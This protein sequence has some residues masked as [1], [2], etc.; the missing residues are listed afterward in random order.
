M[1]VSPRLELDYAKSRTESLSKGPSA[2]SIRNPQPLDISRETILPITNV[3]TKLEPCIQA[4]WVWVNP[5][6]PIF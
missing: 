5:E 4:A 3:I 2:M 6:N 1:P